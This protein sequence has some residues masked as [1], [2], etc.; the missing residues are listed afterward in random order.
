MIVASA[1]GLTHDADSGV[2]V[3]D[4]KADARGDPASAVAA[5]GEPADPWPVGAEADNVVLAPHPADTR[6]IVARAVSVLDP[7][8]MTPTVAIAFWTTR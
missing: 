5:E 4:T 7:D 1:A 6:M 3:G 8:R 2:I